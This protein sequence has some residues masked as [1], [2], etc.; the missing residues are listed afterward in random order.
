MPLKKHK[1]ENR[2]KAVA[3]ARDLDRVIGIVAC[4]KVQAEIGRVVGNG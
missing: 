4:H 1:P 2:S 3:M